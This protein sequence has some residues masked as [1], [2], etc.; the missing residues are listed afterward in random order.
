[1]CSTALPRAFLTHAIV[2]LGGY[3]RAVG[4]LEGMERRD[5]SARRS[6]SIFGLTAR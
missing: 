1:V 4:V 2:T 6:S 5:Y 3:G